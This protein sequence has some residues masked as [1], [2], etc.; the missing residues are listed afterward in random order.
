MS[1]NNKIIRHWPQYLPRALT[2][3]EAPAYADVMQSL[4][5]ANRWAYEFA[6]GASGQTGTSPAIAKNPQGTYG[7]DHSGPPFGTAFVH[8]L[9]TWA[10]SRESSSTA[11]I[12]D[13]G[14]TLKARFWVR[15][16]PRWDG[17]PYSRAYLSLIF[18][19]NGGTTSTVSASFRGPSTATR[20]ETSGSISNG[21]GTYTTFTTSTAYADIV[22][23][24]NAIDITLDRLTGTDNPVLQCATLYQ[25]ARR[26]H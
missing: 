1:G 3:S 4:A 2:T 9:A 8:N 15:P 18:L 6:T 22:P 5:G 10:W 7:H 24:W 11:F 26:S 20:S 12:S 19:G 16:F 13:A 14:A 17:T 23:G 21:A 25:K